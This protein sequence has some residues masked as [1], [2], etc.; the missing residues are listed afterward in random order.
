MSKPTLDARGWRQDGCMSPEYRARWGY[1]RRQAVKYN[2][3]EIRAIVSQHLAGFSTKE[4]AEYHE[5]TANGIDIVLQRHLQ[6]ATTCQSPT[7][8]S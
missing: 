5:R 4:I 7:T 3:A 8:N 2:S 1:P 6:G